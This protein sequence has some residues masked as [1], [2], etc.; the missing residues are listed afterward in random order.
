[1]TTNMVCTFCKNKGIPSPHNHTVRNWTLSDKPVI[2]PVLLAT[3]CT[4]CKTKGHTR[5]YC[6]I[7]NTIKNINNDNSKNSDCDLKRCLNNNHD[8]DVKNKQQK[9]I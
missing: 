6:P 3:E 2:C 4:Y 8:I 1:M 9:L 5:Q 7:R